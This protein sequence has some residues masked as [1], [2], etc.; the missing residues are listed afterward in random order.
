[1][2]KV[3]L[4]NTNLEVSALAMGSDLSGSK[5]DRATAFKLFD[6]FAE[7]GGTFV[8]TAN[9]YASWLAGC[10]GGES[11]TTIGAW[12]KERRNRNQMVVSS[13]LAFDYPG[14]N[15]GLT[16]AEIER[17]CEKSLKRL[18]TDRIDLYYAHRD[19]LA[20]PLEETMK[21]FDMLIKA[22][23]VRVIGAS[24]LSVWRIAEA[25]M[26]SF[27]NK[28]AEYSVIEQRYTYLRPR[29]GADFG[30]Q[31]FISEDLKEFARSH[32]VALVGYSILLQGAYT[33]EDRELPVQFAGPDSDERFAALRTIAAEAGCS[34]SQVII[35]W[36][37]QSR[38]AI[39]PIIAGSKTEQLRENIA[40]LDKTLSAEQMHRLDTAGNP[41]LQQGWIQP[42]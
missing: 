40:A 24:N 9:M 26:V 25:N 1:V 16:A 10:K 34:P 2:E 6:C 39:L 12:M 41:S 17:E 32:G 23:K 38:P 14:C 20:T 15:G 37:R 31:I 29:H 5:I 8:D 18:E 13:K 33:R 35:A 36:M 28:W 22:G 11:E 7:N 27:T 21:A 3:K 4:G 30:P 19:D 42:S